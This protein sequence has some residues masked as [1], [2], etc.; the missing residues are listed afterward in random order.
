M[1]TFIQQT[2]DARVQLVKTLGLRAY[3]CNPLVANGQVLGTPSFGSRGRDRFNDDESEFMETITNYVTVAYERMRLLSQLHERDR[4]KN[5]FLA[6]LAQSCAIPCADPQRGPVSAAQ[7]LDDQDVGGT[8]MI[9]GQ[10]TNLVHLINDLLVISRITRGES[11]PPG[12]RSG[13]PGS[14]PMPSK[15]CSQ[16]SVKAASFGP[17]LFKRHA[18]RFR[19]SDPP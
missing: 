4:R 14:F 3:A 9:D 15:P 8:E 5:E 13:S 17:R 11:G 19:R 10:V 7:G 12:A 6:I 1:A 2:E 18:A 16:R